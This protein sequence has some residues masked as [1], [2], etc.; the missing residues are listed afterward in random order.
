MPPLGGTIPKGRVNL[1]VSA[2]TNF[3]VNTIISDISTVSAN[4]TNFRVNSG[5]VH[6]TTTNYSVIATVFKRKNAKCAK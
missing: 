4:C 2:T 3:R 6:V 1:D 5:V